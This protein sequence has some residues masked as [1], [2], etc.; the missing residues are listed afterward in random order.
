M[1]RNLGYARQQ[2]MKGFTALMGALTQ[3]ELVG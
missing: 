1:K 3:A 2:Q